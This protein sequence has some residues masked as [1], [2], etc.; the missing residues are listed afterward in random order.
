VSFD[1]V[2]GVSLAIERVREQ[3]ALAARGKTHV[4]IQGPSGSGREHVARSLHRRAMPDLREVL[5]PLW[6]PLL[7]A[8]L[9]QTTVTA[10][11][12]AF[13]LSSEERSGDAPGAPSG[14]PTLLLL[15]VDQLTAEAQ[16]ELA[17]FL[18]LPEFDLY[19]ISTCQD[20]LIELAGQGRFRADLAH[21]LSTLVIE[22]PPLAARSEDVPLLCQ[23]LVERLN[24]QGGRQLSGF[25]SE[26]LDELASYP[27]PENVDELA[28]VVQA[29]CQ[30]S[31]GPWVD[32]RHLPEQIRWARQAATH[33]RRD[34]PPIVLAQFLEDIEKELMVRA[35]KRAKGNKTK[36]ARLLGV[37]RARFHRRLEHFG[38]SI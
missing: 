7:D 35:M 17:G 25:T 10:L 2:V 32:V 21:A 5:V 1:E 16:L 12:R 30:A 36:A 29:A 3:V 24:A 33:P 23:C 6:C 37:T 11:V 8:E 9:V 34:E 18:G 26:A 22:I 19:T 14:A 27:W 13:K 20:S 31:D 15:E 4:V 28:A 38:L